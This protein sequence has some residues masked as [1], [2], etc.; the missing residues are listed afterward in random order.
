MN[1][2]LSEKIRKLSALSMML[3]VWLHAQ[4]LEYS[5]GNV[6]FLQRF[7]TQGI[8]RIA[9]PLFF[10]LSGYLY[11]QNINKFSVLV[12]KT[13]TI[14]RIRSLL[15]P[16]IIWS[17]FGFVAV[18]VFQYYVPS[19]FKSAGVVREYRFQEVLYTI[20][21]KP[22]GA[23][24][25][26]FIRDL[27]CLFILSPIIYY[28][29]KYVGRLYLIIL[30]AIW[31]IGKQYLIS[32]ESVFFVSLGSWIAINK[33]G[34]LENR[35][36]C[37]LA[38]IILGL[39]WIVL[40]LIVQYFQIGYSASC[41]CI[42]VGL[43]FIW[44]FYDSYPSFFNFLECIIKYPFFIYCFHEPLMTVLKGIFLKVSY[45]QLWLL[46]VYIVVP[47]LTIYIS[48]LIAT[49]LK[50]NFSTVYKIITGGRQ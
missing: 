38:S 24:Q 39:L 16:F 36:D 34:I 4:L 3:I 14:S 5:V 21:W 42:V 13:K 17:I 20:F 29:T 28:A 27:F 35:R 47:F 30:F 49:L 48:N 11:F 7:C 12:Y 32:I 46:F 40:C 8:T 6:E 43:I 31:L 10:I 23:H 18:S 25:L 50:A 22:I 1:T 2:Y 19:S 37:K 44:L 33:K 41:L 45:I 9:V 26:W 15:F